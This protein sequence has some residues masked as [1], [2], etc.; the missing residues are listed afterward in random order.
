MLRSAVEKRTRDGNRTTEIKKKEVPKTECG[1][2]TKGIKRVAEPGVGPKFQ[3]QPRFVKERRPPRTWRRSRRR[4]GGGEG[5]GGTD[6]HLG[7][8][9]SQLLLGFRTLRTDRKMRAVTVWTAL[10][11]ACSSR[12]LVSGIRY[13]DPIAPQTASIREIAEKR[14]EL[15]EPTCEELR[16]MWRYTKRQ[17]RAAK[18]TSGYP[19]YPQPFT[20]NMWQ[21]YPDHSK[22][23]FAYRGRTANRAYSRA[24][25]GA[26]IYG[27]M[28]HKA[29]AGSRLRNGMRQRT[30]AFEEVA[31]LY[32]TVNRQSP[33][34]RRR[35]TSF[36]VGG[37][38]SAPV[39]QVPQ[40]GSFQ[41]LK[42]LIR[43]ERARELQ[44]QHMAEEVVSNTA[45][46]KEATNDERPPIAQHH[47]KHFLN[48]LPPLEAPSK[49]NYN[50]GQ[51]R[52]MSNVPNIGQAWSRS[53]PLSREYMLR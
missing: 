52:Y 35:L 25:G 33:S 17:S 39:S 46:F 18:T 7:A 26:P 41:H 10:V 51:G 34:T 19:V 16:A 49:V 2:Q 47:R 6:C 53:G 50:Y 11:L 22:T 44:E 37:G 15:T 36:R 1:S 20:Y 28:V 23:S 45:S 12:V 42:D 30:R 27:R 40:A 48:S 8:T 43:A 29:P 32:G 21:A 3:E 38:M 5:G 4:C 9:T 24:A 14:V 31:R 13:F